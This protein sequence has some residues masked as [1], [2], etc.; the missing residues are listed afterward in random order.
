VLA[1]AW[2]QGR[3]VRARRSPA[4]GCAEDLSAVGG[5][6]RRDSRPTGCG[7]PR[8][9]RA[10]GRMSITVLHPR[11]VSSAADCGYRMPALCS[12]PRLRCF[13]QRYPPGPERPTPASGTRAVFWS[14][15]RHPCSSNSL[16]KRRAPAR[17]QSCT[18][19][20]RPGSATRP[21]RG[22]AARGASGRPAGASAGN[23][24]A[25]PRPARRERASSSRGGAR[26]GAGHRRRRPAGRP[27]R[28]S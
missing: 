13:S 26:P 20:R 19:A 1:R 5:E 12:Q 4:P 15:E 7:P 18:A 8:H 25:P 11:P 6:G 9:A 17:Q 28:P 27:P 2:P 21:R 24:R 3:G 23:R 22:R 16:T 10:G 14:A